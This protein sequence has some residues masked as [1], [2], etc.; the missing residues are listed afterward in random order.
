[1]SRH[2]QNM[3]VVE[4]VEQDDEGRDYRIRV[5]HEL[6]ARV[7]FTRGPNSRTGEIE[8]IGR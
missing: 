4:Q 8:Q 6:A 7:G 1:M 2:E 3:F 5:G